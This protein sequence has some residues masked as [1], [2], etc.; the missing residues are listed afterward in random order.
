MFTGSREDAVWR[1][2]EASGF[3]SPPTPSSC[4]PVYCL[5][6]FFPVCLSIPFGAHIPNVSQL[7]LET[8]PSIGILATDF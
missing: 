1:R 8:F 2:K 4:T 7:G 6:P 3:F 5:R